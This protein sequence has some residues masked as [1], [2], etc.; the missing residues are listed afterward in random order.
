[1]AHSHDHHCASAHHHHH[2]TPNQN[3]RRFGFAITLNLIY[4]GIEFCYGLLTNSTALIADAGHN[5]SDVFGLLLSWYAIVL[6]RR[7]PSV[8][9]TYGLR[10]SSIL[11]ALTNG[12]LLLFACGAIAWEAAHRFAAPPVIEGFTISTIAGIGIFINGLSALLLLKDSHH[13]L[14]MRSAYLHMVADTAVSVSVVIAGIA[15]QYGNWYWLDPS[16]S[17]IIVLVIVIGTW[18]L[19]REALQLALS[20]VPK[21]IDSTKISH[22]LSQLEGV[23]EIHDLHIWG[24]STTENALTAHLVMP[25]GYPGDE[26]IDKINQSLKETYAIH[27]ATLQ[28][29]LGTTH[30]HCTLHTPTTELHLHHHH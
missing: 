15:M 27:H 4:V 9:Y 1:M 8:K 25:N 18:S 2:P 24:L 17:L 20:A 22:F 26:F 14:N 7:K 19:L 29:E 30:H 13:D 12:M 11:A 21:T 5:I 3:K 16:M 28:I 23:T 6:T 10:S